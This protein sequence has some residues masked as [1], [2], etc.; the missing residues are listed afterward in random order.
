MMNFIKTSLRKKLICI[1]FLTASLVIGLMVYLL[2]SRFSTINEAAN[3]RYMDA[4][5]QANA[6]ILS[7]ILNQHVKHLQDFAHLI[8]KRKNDSYNDKQIFIEQLVS[9]LSDQDGVSDAYVDF[10]RGVFFS[11]KATDPET[12][13]GIEAFHRNGSIVLSTDPSE[14]VSEDDDWYNKPR[15]TRKP[16]LVEP[17]EWA[18]PSDET[19]RKMI[20]I[21]CPLIFDGVFTGAIGIDLELAHLQAAVFSRMTDQTERGYVIFVSY[22]GVQASH[23]SGEQLFVPVGNDMSPEEQSKL[24]A[25][26]KKGEQ[27][28]TRKKSLSSGDNSLFIYK[29]VKLDANP[30]IP[31]SLATVRSL[32]ILS[33]EVR[34]SEKRA[35]VIAIAALFLWMAAFYILFGRIFSPVQRSSE[36]IRK[37]ANTRDL[38]LRTPVLSH[39]E[40]GEQNK[41][42]NE[43]MDEMRKAVSQ[44]KMC[45]GLLTSSSEELASVSRHLKDSSS[46]TVNQADATS[47]AAEQM[48]MN[49]NAMADGAEKASANAGEVAKSAERMSANMQTVASA[50]EEMSMS[51]SK[52]AANADEA[53]KVAANAA[54]KSGEATVVMGKLGAAAKEIGQ[55]T[56]L[57]KKI[58]DKTNLLALN[59]T[60]EA[61]SAGEAG[62]GFAVVAGEIKSLANQSAQSADDIAMRIEGIQSGAANAVRVIDE[63]SSIIQAIN[64]SVEVIVGHVEQQ[65]NASNEIASNVTQASTGA[66][67]VADSIGEVA[68][69]ARDMSHNAGEA[70]KGATHVHN[71]MQVFNQVARETSDSSLQM[72]T[73]AVELSKIS[74]K[75]SNVVDEFKA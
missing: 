11:E 33:A 43:L 38:T 73:V 7:D 36:L 61:A 35:V 28:E 40:I 57:I 6:D 55:V 29:P 66:H 17:Y 30:T 42:F 62:K 10:E 52:I 47:A 16:Y 34:N 3:L 54:I 44:T 70:V 65:T 45:A 31:W 15:E 46:D 72:E 18:Y 23:P 49:I 60:I 75:L 12:Y 26:I 20:S 69:G 64:N 59:A 27:Y 41:S 4:K 5:A 71:T 19:E 8:E 1:L 67:R 2:Y 53:S 9:R 22:E 13:Y 58:A 32:T 63:V 21:S 39:D 68:K 24:Q 37:I 51:I 48:I 14:E 56:D 25:A 74:E 50:V